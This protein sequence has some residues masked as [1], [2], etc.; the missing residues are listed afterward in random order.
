MAVVA[1]LYPDR[2]NTLIHR[3][4]S[5][6][7][8]LP[9]L[10]ASRLTPGRYLC[11]AAKR[12]LSRPA[13]RHFIIIA[14]PLQPW[15]ILFFQNDPTQQQAASGHTWPSSRPCSCGL[16]ITDKSFIFILSEL[17]LI[18]PLFRVWC[19]G[20]F[21][22]APHF[23]AA[24]ARTT[25]APPHIPYSYLPK[26]S[27]VPARRACIKPLFAQATCFFHCYIDLASHTHRLKRCPGRR[28]GVNTGCTHSWHRGH[29]KRRT[30]PVPHD[31]DVADN[32]LLERTRES[33]KAT[34]ATLYLEG[35]T[36]QSIISRHG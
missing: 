29:R 2:V 13:D 18:P 32:T 31:L 3:Y 23:G 4:T 20:G 11:N 15:S 16:L 35:Q 21:R 24:S 1:R 28:S 7:S 6:S 33:L 30:A 25:S 17:L 22:S 34:I 27:C 8:L 36:C 12:I 14:P 10:P 5:H 19:R 26:K 9:I